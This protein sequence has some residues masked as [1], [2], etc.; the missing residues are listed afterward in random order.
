MPALGQVPVP[1]GRAPSAHT[2]PSHVP[3]KPILVLPPPAPLLPTVPL[4][5][6]LLVVTVAT[7]WSFIAFATCF[8][9]TTRLP[10]WERPL[11][12]VLE[13]SKSLDFIDAATHPPSFVVL[14]PTTTMEGPLEQV[15]EH[16]VCLYALHQPPLLFDV[17]HLNGVLTWLA[18]PVVPTRLPNFGNP[19]Q[20]GCVVA[21]VKHPYYLVLQHI[22]S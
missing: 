2:R 12:Q 19:Q 14:L 17:S 18:P 5:S 10:Q 9:A 21:H 7:A 13:L 3:T 15:L 6:L 1:T 4:L 16:P 20:R 22:P 8:I 11:E